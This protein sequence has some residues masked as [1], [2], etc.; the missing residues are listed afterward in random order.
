MLD[1]DTLMI[2]MKDDSRFWLEVFV[3]STPT[4][5]LQLL[6]PFST[7]PESM[8]S[9]MNTGSSLNPDVVNAKS[10]YIHDPSSDRMLVLNFRTWNTYRIVISSHR[11]LDIIKSSNDDFKTLSWSHWSPNATRW[12]ETSSWGQIPSSF[13][14]QGASVYFSFP[15]RDFLERN[16]MSSNFPDSSGVIFCD[17][18]PRHVRRYLST[19]SQSPYPT[20]HLEGGSNQE[21][22]S[23]SWHCEFNPQHIVTEEWV[24]RSDSFTEDVHCRL[25][26][27]AT[28]HHFSEQGSMCPIMDYSPIGLFLVRSLTS[29]NRQYLNENSHTD[30]CVFVFLSS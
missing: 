20:H 8:G 13:S 16:R 26:F 12:F 10:Y 28:L 4:R 23:Q 21:Q 25:P 22:S 7:K 5:R 15:T 17:F 6:L 19:V 18:N 2:L 24:L 14:T 27:R 3:M 29:R 30:L 1:A 9:Y 11:V